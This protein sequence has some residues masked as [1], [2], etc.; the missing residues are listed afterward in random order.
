[1]GLPSIEVIIILETALTAII[2]LGIAVHWF[3]KRS[4]KQ[5]ELIDKLQNLLQKELVKQI[6]AQAENNKNNDSA[7]EVKEASNL[8]A[9]NNELKEKIST[10]ERRIQNLESFKKLFFAMESR[11]REFGDP[12]MNKLE[13]VIQNISEEDN[14][15]NDSN[16]N[17]LKKILELLKSLNLDTDLSS[18][19]LTQ[20]STNDKST[21]NLIRR[22]LD[23]FSDNV[24]QQENILIDLRKREKFLDNSD[25]DQLDKMETLLKKSEDK[26]SVLKR[27]LSNVRDQVSYYD[28][29]M[30]KI[31]NL[32]SRIKILEQ[33]EKSLNK[34][35]KSLRTALQISPLEKNNKTEEIE[36]SSTDEI[37]HNN[38]TASIEEKERQLKRT[39]QDFKTLEIEYE[40]LFK[41][42]ETLLQK[43]ANSKDTSASFSKLNVTPEQLE[44]LG[45]IKDELD[46]KKMLLD[47]KNLECKTL[48]QNYL[49]LVQSHD[50]LQSANEELKH[51]KVEYQLLEEQLKS[52]ESVSQSK[53]SEQASEANKKYNDLKTTHTKTLQEL[54]I[55][56]EKEKHY[57]KLQTE[58][59]ALEQKLANMYEKKYSS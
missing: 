46:S 53:N 23:Q 1:M 25:Q 3:S 2:A 43:H 59:A 37:N 32:K 8:L 31:K 16:F 48:E 50:E 13:T 30:A 27:E 22:E 28:M 20:D 7:P 9:L 34:T 19:S 49:D 6:K 39:K 24:I 33:R 26:V 45:F 40:N 36:V 41:N 42:Y 38:F 51:I 10:Y 44:E 29:N 21:V 4:R 35:I 58:Y 5:E 12:A 18:L 11:V 57:K 54:K 15:L 17:T 14:S 52:A 55:L 47:R 56:K